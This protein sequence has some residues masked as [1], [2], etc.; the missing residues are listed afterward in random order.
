M[1]NILIVIPAY[2]EENTIGILVKKINK[3]F[4]VLVINDGSTD[5]TSLIAKKSGAKVISLNKNC[6]V[7]SAINEG[8]KF[9]KKNNFNYVV[10]IDADGQHSVKDL[11]K[12]AKI[13]KR[14]EKIDIVISERK[15]FP[16]FS[17]KIFSLYTLYRFGVKDLLSGLK[18]YKII[19]FNRYGSFDTFKSIG[20]E[21]SSFAIEN[22]FNYKT[23]KIS[24]L[25]RKDKS[26]VGGKIIGNLKILKALI[27]LMF[28]KF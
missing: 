25:E 3:Y 20:T 12:I 6:G 18:A 23:I 4:K 19:I 27:N 15:N 7:D 26:R 2:N 17:E 13:I 16:R 10:T 11:R 8:F 22:N 9:A 28:K 1:K 24:I 5:Q 14:N 21:L